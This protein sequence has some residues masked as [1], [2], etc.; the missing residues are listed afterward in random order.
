MDEM[1]TKK[2]GWIKNVAIIFLSIMLILTF[3]SNTFMNRSLAE[4]AT[5][6]VT[7]GEIVTKIRGGGTVTANE[8]YE[9]VLS[10]GRTIESVKVQVGDEVREGDVLFLLSEGDSAELEQAEAALRAANLSYQ[11]ALINATEKDYAK[12]NRDIQLAREELQLAQ[13]ELNSFSGGSM[14]LQQAK[15]QMDPAKAVMDASQ[16][17]VD[18]YQEQLNNLGGGGGGGDTS[19]LYSAYLAAEDAL[20]QARQKLQSQMLTQGNAYKTLLEKVVEDRFEQA[21]I[22]TSATDADLSALKKAYTKY[23]YEKFVG[24]S[25]SVSSAKAEID[26]IISEYPEDVRAKAQA[27]SDRFVS[28][29][30]P[31]LDVYM[32]AA[33][34]GGYAGAGN[35]GAQIVADEKEKAAYDALKES[36]KAVSEAQRTR[37]AAYSAY[38]EAVGNDNSGEY[39]RINRL[40]QKAKESLD[41][42]TATYENMKTIYEGIQTASTA[43]KEK[44]RALEDLVFALEEQKKTDDKA[45]QLE[46]LDLQEMRYTIA[47][48]Q[49]KVNELRQDATEPE[50]KAK[51][52]GI[53]TSIS[54][55]AGKPVEANTTICTITVPDMGYNVS[56]SVTSEQARKVRVGD[57]ATIANYWGGDLTATLA[58]IKT[59]P[60]N[61]Q[62]SK[63]LTFDIHGEV[64]PGT[65]LNLSVGQ[66]SAQYD[67]IVP[68]SALRSDSNGDFVLVVTSKSSP[69]GNRY[70]ATRV[71]VEKVLSDDANTAV[72][73]GLNPYDYV[74]TTSSKPIKDK[75]MVR[76]AE[77]G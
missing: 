31:Q 29:W 15:S 30:E 4:V 12:E 11:K 27:A 24:D 34:T 48:A 77:S 22:G 33:T 63:I 51:V 54:A 42:A 10:Q 59:D 64:E 18:K 39:D 76:L 6:Y 46:Q 57:E 69:L 47:D 44:Q 50:V 23:E 67:T 28:E 75:D 40:L 43:V 70:I 49:E 13:A 1:Q 9:V 56:F 25:E 35:Q 32:E 71:D 65:T 36:L 38:I 14:T 60:K 68:N 26:K 41:K 17:E 5:A 61:P 16:R 72:S 20:S 19:G 7:S 74:I 8:S 62:S 66:K 55:T 21:A 58:S 53:V 52:S 45:I 73:G 37:D 3:F 2:R